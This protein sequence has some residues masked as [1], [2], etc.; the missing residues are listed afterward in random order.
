LFQQVFACYCVCASLSPP[1]AGKRPPYEL[2]SHVER[3]AIFASVAVA[4]F[5]STID[6]NVV[7]TALPLIVHDLGQADL[8]PW[9]LSSFMLTSSAVMVVYGRF[10]DIYGRRLVLL[11]AIAIFLIGSVLC[12]AATDMWFLIICRGIQGACM[13]V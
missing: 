7:I 9:V 5:L 8:L 11:T 3:Q 10:S 2:L 4:L 13:C 1:I 6:Q 12:G